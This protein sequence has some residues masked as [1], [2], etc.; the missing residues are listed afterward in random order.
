MKLVSL[1]L[2]I[3]VL[4]YSLPVQSQN[5]TPAQDKDYY[6]FTETDEVGAGFK[7]LSYYLKNTCDRKILFFN[8]KPDQTTGY[9]VLKDLP[10]DIL[11]VE[12]HRSLKICKLKVSGEMSGIT[13]QA[14]L[15]DPS[16]GFN[17]YPENGKNYVFFWKSSETADRITFSYLLKNIS[18]RWIKFYAFDLETASGLALNNELASSAYLWQDS[19]M[20][21]IEF[22]VPKTVEAPLLNWTAEFTDLQPSGDPFCDAL[23]QILEAS[24]EGDF[25]LVRGA[26][27]GNGTYKCKVVLPEIIGYS[28]METDGKWFYAGRVGNSGLKKEIYTR[29]KIFT[30]KIDN[31]IPDVIALKILKNKTTKNKSALFSGVLNDK[32]YSILLAVEGSPSQPADYKLTL[33]IAGK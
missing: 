12:P 21:V 9:E 28:I 4:F 8:F 30:V 3:A 1:S 26:S 20:K 27:A 7:V 13:W 17:K 24:G 10:Q 23:V 11:I 19:V 31:C 5:D 6:Y 22:S 15:L 2:F 25:S 18:D 29:F 16:V 14:K 33:T 32:S